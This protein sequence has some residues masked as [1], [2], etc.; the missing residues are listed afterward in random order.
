MMYKKIQL[1]SAFMLLVFSMGAQDIESAYKLLS[2]GKAEDAVEMAQKVVSADPANLG[3]QFSLYNLLNAAENYTEA[4]KVLE[5]IKVADANG[6]YGKTADV[7]QQLAAGANAEDLTSA[8]DKAIRKGKN[9]KGFLY[10]TVGEYF[11]FGQKK[12]PVKAIFYIKTAI[13]DYSLNNASTRMILGD[14]Y[15]AKN[16]A[17]NAVT[18][19][20]YAMELDKTSAVPHYK[21]GTTYIRARNYEF[22]VP[23]LRKAIETD[24]NYMLAYKDLGKYYY[25]AGKYEEAKEN[26]GKYIASTKPTL[27]ENIQYSNILY[28]AKDYE[29]GV[30]VMN[31]V[32][33]ADK[34]SKYVGINRLLG[35]SYYETG[36]Y[37]KAEQLLTNFFSNHD[38]L[39]I[40]AEDYIYLGKIQDKLG[41]DSL[42]MAKYDSMSRSSY[43][44]AFQMD[45]TKEGVI[46]EIADSLY[47]QKRYDEAGFFYFARAKSTNLAAD[48]FYATRADYLGGNYVRGMEAAQGIINKLPDELAGHLWLARNAALLDTINKGAMAVPLYEM[49]ITKGNIDKAKNGKDILEALNWLTVYN[50]NIKQDYVKAQSYN[51]QALEIDANNEQVMK[52]FNFLTDVTTNPPKKSTKKG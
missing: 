45:S 7:I 28:F 3:N 29:K 39:K 46:K 4:A 32:K 30:Q 42:S 11:L 18:N 52:L 14:A 40:L 13:D 44:M 8:I 50:I 15:S 36:K 22:G 23:E 25:D 12:N 26:Y 41:S 17:G 51:D 24:P 48:Y 31:Q 35:Y 10:R 33:A 27:I 9:A 49:V 16:D 38:T 1:F 19:Y 21:I 20:E 5:G 34:D 47:N 37:D 43:L 6:P 2:Y